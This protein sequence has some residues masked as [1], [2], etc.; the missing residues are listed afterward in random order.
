MVCEWD[1]PQAHL[2]KNSHAGLM[3]QGKA[4]SHFKKIVTK[5]S[6]IVKDIVLGG[7]ISV[8]MLLCTYLSPLQK[9]QGSS[10]FSCLL[11]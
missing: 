1:E 2:T 9:H 3:G 8:S 4:H 5:G 7:P 6:S 11:R 10:T